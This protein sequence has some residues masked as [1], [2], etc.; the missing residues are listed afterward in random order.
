M[1]CMTAA[2]SLGSTL[3]EKV[4][5]LLLTIDNHAVTSLQ[6]GMEVAGGKKTGEMG[7]A[8]WGGRRD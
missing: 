5:K 7:A 1:R 2:S 4:V 3:F 8:G 6:R